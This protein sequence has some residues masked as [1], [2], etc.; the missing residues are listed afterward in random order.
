MREGRTLPSH[1]R[2]T[3]P[4]ARRP[5]GTSTASGLPA[6]SVLERQ[7]KTGVREIPDLDISLAQIKALSAYCRL[8]AQWSQA[9]NLVG[10]RTLPEIVSQHILDSLS[11][12]SFLP[13]GGRRVL[14]LGTGAGLPGLPLAVVHPDRQFT[15]LDRNRKKT[16]FVRQAKLE[17]NLS[18]IKVV[19]EEASHYRGGPF[20]CIMA[21]A[22]G[23]LAEIIQSS[24]HLIA[25]GGIYLL[26]KGPD[27]EQELRELPRRW[28][29]A[30]EGLERSDKR[31]PVRTVIVLRAPDADRGVP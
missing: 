12:S 20:E 6:E 26:P 1:A 16:R 4:Q 11:L 27:I 14:D 19:T 23:S 30:V 17:L 9:Y 29:V 5:R 24:T 8:V 13:P 25:A 18:N 15:L 7:L 28:D 21:R 10:A 22:V 2:E 3:S 31:S